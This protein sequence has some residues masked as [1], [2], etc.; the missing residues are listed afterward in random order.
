MGLFDA[1]VLNTVKEGS[2]RAALQVSVTS[3]AGYAFNTRSPTS[4]SISR[5]IAVNFGFSNSSR[6]RT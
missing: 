4:Q 6:D 5:F 3:L 1:L 2:I